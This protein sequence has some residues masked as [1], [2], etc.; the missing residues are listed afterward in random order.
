MVVCVCVCG[1]RRRGAIFYRSTKVRTVNKFIKVATDKRLLFALVLA[2][3][4]IV[5]IIIIIAVCCCVV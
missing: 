1:C 5:V 4:S 2:V 3:S